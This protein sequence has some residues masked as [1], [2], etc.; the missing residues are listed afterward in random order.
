MAE[1]SEGRAAEL[2]R[3]P[4]PIGNGSRSPVARGD[5]AFGHVEE[6]LV[7]RRCAGRVSPVSMP[8]HCRTL[9]QSAGSRAPSR[10]AAVGSLS[11]TSG[12][13]AWNARTAGA[14]TACNRTG[15]AVTRKRPVRPAWAA[16]TASLPSP[17][18]RRMRRARDRDGTEPGGAHAGGVVLE[19]QARG[20]PSRPLSS[21]AGRL[22]GKRGRARLPPI[23]QVGAASQGEPGRVGDPRKHVKRTKPATLDKFF[24]SPLGRKFDG[25]R[26][27][28][29]RHCQETT[30]VVAVCTTRHPTR[31]CRGRAIPLLV[32]LPD[33]RGKIPAWKAPI[34][35]IRRQR[36]SETKRTSQ[37][38]RWL[39]PPYQ[40]CNRLIGHLAKFLLKSLSNRNEGRRH[41]QS[42]PS[43]FSRLSHGRPWKWRIN[44]AW[45]AE[46]GCAERLLAGQS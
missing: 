2:T 40:T 14:T 3:P 33:D 30:P 46:H 6:A 22:P 16:A 4:R 7:R 31:P 13:A 43:L 15:A 36:Q 45:T 32:P 20:G 1:T 38:I 28:R 29:L 25:R 41:S 19:H 9:R 18:S 34:V 11:S 26:R 8:P 21:H 5:D 23:R 39:R 35:I 37:E 24:S 10:H 44:P 42:C 27:R 12:K 17:F